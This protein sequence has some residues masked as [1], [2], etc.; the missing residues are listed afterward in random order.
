MAES[1]RSP[2]YLARSSYRRRRLI[3]AQRLLPI[4]LFLLY[5]LPLLWGGS[6]QD[7]PIG[8]GVRG[9]VHVFSVWLG[10]IVISGLIARALMK[11]ETLEDASRDFGEPK[12]TTT[13]DQSGDQGTGDL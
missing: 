9:Y 13:S 6:S 8:G 7:D 4:F 1:G 5:L 10:A 3:D 2:L 11:A 12:Q